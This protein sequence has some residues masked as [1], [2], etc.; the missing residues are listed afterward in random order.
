MFLISVMFTGIIMLFEFCI[1]KSD[2][3]NKA[4]ITSELWISYMYYTCTYLLYC[5]T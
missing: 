5:D 2:V 1:Q 4:I 3:A